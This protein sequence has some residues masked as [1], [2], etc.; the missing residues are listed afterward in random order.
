MSIE[1]EFVATFTAVSTQRQAIYQ[2]F[3]DWLACERSQQNLACYQ[4]DEQSTIEQLFQACGLAKPA[5]RF[6]T[7][8]S[9]LLDLADNR[10]ELAAD[11]A[12]AFLL[13]ADYCATPYASWYLE[14]DKRLYG[15]AEQKMR[16]FLTENALQIHHEFKEPA[17]HLA[18]FLALFAYWVA[19]DAAS[20]KPEQ[21]AKEQAQFLQQALLSWLPQWQQR[22]QQLQL[23]TDVYPALAELL[24][25][26]IQADLAYLS[27]E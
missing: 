16:E 11:F 5:Q 12:S 20:N 26:F 17:D 27:A 4:A 3:A 7:A 1:N 21:A 23:K 2:W 18:V 8:L 24:L 9:Q 6:Q 19:Q 25:N 22:C 15:D 10:I 14:A 13:A